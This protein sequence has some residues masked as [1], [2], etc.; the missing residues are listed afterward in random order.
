MQIRLLTLRPEDIRAAATALRCSRAAV[1]A[2]IDTGVDGHPLAQL[3]L[4]RRGAA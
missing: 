3:H 1:E 2:V 4:V